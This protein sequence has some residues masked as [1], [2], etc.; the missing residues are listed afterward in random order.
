MNNKTVVAM[1]AITLAGSAD[2]VLA[3]TATTTFQVDATVIG[4][5]NVSATNLAFGNY[6]TL[7]AT[8]TDATST[9]TVQ[10]S[11]STAFDIGLDAGTG[12]G[13]TVATRKLT[14]GADTLNYSLYQESARTT[15]WGNTVSTDTVAGTGTGLDIVHTVYG[16][17]AAGQVVN[18]GAYS[19][20]V[21]VTVTF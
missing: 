20:T 21:T 7:S 17:I 5:C 6:D 4:S 9:V 11:L 12:T 3:A 14:K 13:A 10:C 18:T 15:V 19:D 16:R 8:P 1:L 2:S